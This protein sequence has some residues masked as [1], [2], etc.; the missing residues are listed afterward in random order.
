MAAWGGLLYSLGGGALVFGGCSALALVW[1][2]VSLTMQEPPYV[3]SLRIL[4][5]EGVEA[6]PALEQKL[7]A[8]DGVNDVLL[9]R[10]ERS[11]YVKVDSK[12]VS[13]QDL[14]LLVIDAGH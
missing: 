2:G 6:S 8:C 11:L 3:S 9:A 7:R 4:L 14:E 1:L 13:R 10:K 12:R 5:P